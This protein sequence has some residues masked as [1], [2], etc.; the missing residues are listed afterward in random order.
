MHLNRKPWE[1]YLV[2]LDTTNQSIVLSY[3]QIGYSN[4]SLYFPIHVL[5]CLGFHA[6]A[7][8]AMNKLSQDVTPLMKMTTE[9][10]TEPC[11]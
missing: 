6:Q 9:L 10:P 1:N 5:A 11:L 3:A 2:L 4:V 7:F 8:Q